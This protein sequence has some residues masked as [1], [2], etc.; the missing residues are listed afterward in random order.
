MRRIVIGLVVLSSI[1]L[2]A[3]AAGTP[4]AGNETVAAVTAGINLG[5]A[6]ARAA[7]TTQAAANLVPVRALVLSLLLLLIAAA[8]RWVD[9][10]EPPR[11]VRSLVRGQT[12][13]GRG[14]PIAS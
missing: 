8:I 13:D 7:S 2:G 6:P 9:L 4:V 11:L 5:T 1:L 3:L 12:R 10:H 14:P